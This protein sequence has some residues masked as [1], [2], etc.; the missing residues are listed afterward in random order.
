M[1]R[2]LGGA[3]AL[4]VLV[5]GVA[6][7]AA[8]TLAEMKWLF[9]DQYAKLVYDSNPDAVGTTDL[10]TYDGSNAAVKVTGQLDATQGIGAAYSTTFVGTGDGLVADWMGTMQLDGT[11]Y[12]G[13]T[14]VA[15]IAYFNK[16]I[17]LV[18][19]AQGAGQTL[20]ID[21]VTAGL[22]LTGDQADN[23]G[24]EL[25]GGILGASGRPM[26]PGVDPAFYF[27]ASITITDVSDTDDLHVGWRT[28]EIPNATYANFDS[29]ASIGIVASAAT[30][31]IQITTEDDA[32][33]VTTTDTTDTWADAASK[34][35][36]VYVGSDRAVTYTINNVAPT[37]TAAFSFDTG[38]PVIPH[39]WWIHA[40]AADCVPVLTEWTVGWTNAG[41]R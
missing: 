4:V 21:M 11:V 30:A 16:G 3:A 13:T 1:K 39:V 19:W 23:E 37:A 15:N 5:A 20:D 25:V 9:Y 28:V 41:N 35:L 36:C 17:K 2:W 26:V 40:G 12:D 22:D 27:C 6:V 24:F 14:A 7:F 8:P 32:G 38:E 29:K 34:R 31:A 18:Y 10:V 33:G